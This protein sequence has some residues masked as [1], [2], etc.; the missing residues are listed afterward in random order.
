MTE[1]KQAI[2]LWIGYAYKVV[3]RGLRLARTTTESL[4][5]DH[6]SHCGAV[7][8][9]NLQKESSV[10]AINLIPICFDNKI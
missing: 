3:Y 10:K 8:L 5:C 9:R 4:T 1:A 6:R 2:W 7:P